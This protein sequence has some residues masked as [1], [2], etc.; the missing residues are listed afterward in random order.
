M[1]SFIV[2]LLSTF[3]L[4]AALPAHATQVNRDQANQYFATC[5]SKAAAGANANSM[6]ALCACSSARLMQYMTAEELE[7]LKAGGAGSQAAQHKM[8]LDVYAPCSETIAA[9]MIG[10]E[11]VNNKQLYE[12][13][14]GYDIPK[15]CACSAQKSA[16]WYRGKARGLMADILK[17]DPAVTN[18]VGALISHPQTKNQILNNLVACSAQSADANTLN[19]YVPTGIQPPVFSGPGK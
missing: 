13:N 14:K 2:A 9:D 6:T 11:C 15:I 5:I 10:F 12:M 16:D 17:K 7:L 19:K 3:L 8:L 4:I 1:R 18:A